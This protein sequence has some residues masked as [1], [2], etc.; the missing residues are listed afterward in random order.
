[1]LA[2]EQIVE[3]ALELNREDR[4]YLADVLE[5]SLSSGEFEAGEVA[6]AWAAEIE[7]RIAAYDRGE[8]HAAGVDAAFDRIRKQLADHRARKVIVLNCSILPAAE[9]EAADAAIWYD[10]QR[11]GLGDEFLSEFRRALDRIAAAPESFSRLETYTGKDDVRRCMLKQFPYIV[12][13]VRRAEAIIV[14][15]V[16]HVRRRPLYWLERLR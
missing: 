8:I 3:Q 2:R 7:Q 4:L 12:V 10:D 13:F 6:T 9:L 1:M 14:V 15:A 5:Q 16:S 11:P